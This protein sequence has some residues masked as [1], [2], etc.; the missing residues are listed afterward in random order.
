MQKVPKDELRTLK[1]QRE[2]IR[3]NQ[4][5]TL[6]MKSDGQVSSTEIA[7]IWQIPLSR[8]QQEID[9]LVMKYSIP[10]NRVIRGYPTFVFDKS[11]H[12]FS[13]EDQIKTPVKSKAIS[14]EIPSDI[15]YCG[16]CGAENRGSKFCPA[17]GANISEF[18]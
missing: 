17:C 14:S 16:N 9:Y 15:S 10:I 11:I 5:V 13:I 3:V 2:I 4:L 1:V 12:T 18:A 8:V 7:E 6:A